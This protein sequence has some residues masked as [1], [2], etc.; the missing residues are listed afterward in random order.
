MNASGAMSNSDRAIATGTSTALDRPVWSALTSRHAAFA[1]GGELA[2]RF[3]HGIVPFLDIKETTPACLAAAVSLVRPGEQ[4][5][6]FRLGP[7]DPPD[8]LVVVDRRTAHQMV[9]AGG[10]PPEV[11]TLIRPLDRRDVPAM[12]ELVEIAK[13]GSFGPRSIEL[14]EFFGIREEGRL[15]A[16]AGERMKVDGATEI[17]AVCVHPD[18]RRR[19]YS[20]AL[21]DGLTRRIMDRN[22]VPFVHVSATKADAIALHQGQ[23]FVARKTFHSTIVAC[24]E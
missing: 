15:A 9:F 19:G 20:K 11:S 8:S 18:Y 3:Q 10:R 23:G 4:V 21:L 22:E 14:G 6:F 17:T 7:I 24:A 16:M 13:P 5:T 1:L 2:L 12:L